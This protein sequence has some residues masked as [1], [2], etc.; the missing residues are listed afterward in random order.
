MPAVA[1]F[2]DQ[3][4]NGLKNYILGKGI[5]ALQW[6]VYIMK[7]LYIDGHVKEKAGTDIV[8]A[9]RDLGHDAQVYSDQPIRVS[10]LD[11]G[12][13]QDLVSCVRE[14]QIEILLSIHFIMCA[15]LAAFQLGIRY[16]AMLW[17]A[18]YTGIYNPLGRMGN[19]WVSTFDKLDMAR[20]IEGGVK[21]V[22]Y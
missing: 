10:V 2:E 14:H 19:V 3:F 21:H 4:R 7:I 8:Q 13:V 5:E 6:A 16:I 18:P 12:I 17:D 11:D 1:F 9:L 20:L 15:E 22:L